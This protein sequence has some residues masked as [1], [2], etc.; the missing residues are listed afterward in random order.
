MELGEGVNRCD[1]EGLGNKRDF[2]MEISRA[3]DF[4]VKILDLWGFIMNLIFEV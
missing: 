3:L 4:L 2:F 1:F